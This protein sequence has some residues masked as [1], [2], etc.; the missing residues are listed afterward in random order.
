MRL[1]LIVVS[2]LLLSLVPVQQQT[3]G[4][5]IVF[6]NGN[7]YTASDTSP[8]AEAAMA[9]R[10]TSTLPACRAGRARPAALLPGKLH[11]RPN[12]PTRTGI[13][14]CAH[15]SA[16]KGVVQSNPCSTSFIH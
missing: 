4:A 3:A 9:S 11:F 1:V 15:A 13:D 8:R 10:N 5:D 12:G 7:V 14:S 16:M 6:K 2:V